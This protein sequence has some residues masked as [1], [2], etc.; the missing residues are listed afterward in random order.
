MFAK[1]PGTLSFYCLEPLYFC[2]VKPGALF[3]KFL[4][5]RA[6]F[7][8]AQILGAPLPFKGPEPWSPKPLW[9]PEGNCLSMRPNQ[10][11]LH[12]GGHCRQRQ[13]NGNPFV[14]ND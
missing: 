13:Q 7:I 1:D 8:V 12:C 14:F 3:F 9:N 6:L 10:M 4:D 11:Y 5:P 2:T